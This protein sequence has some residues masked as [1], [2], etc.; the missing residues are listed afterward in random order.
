MSPL[1]NNRIPLYLNIFADR[2]VYFYICTMSGPSDVK[3]HRMSANWSSAPLQPLRVSRTSTLLAEYQPC[4]RNVDSQNRML[5]DYALRPQL[6][7][8]IYSLVQCAD[9]KAMKQGNMRNL[10]PCRHGTRRLHSPPSFSHR[11]RIHTSCRLVSNTEE[12][13]KYVVKWCCWT[14][15]T[16]NQ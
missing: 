12:V 9:Q 2:G 6:Q 15:S 7:F 3:Q 8:Q 4:V 11:C 5:K 13:I 1:S 14:T 16:F 10:L